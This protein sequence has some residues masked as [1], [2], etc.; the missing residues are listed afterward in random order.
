M[1]NENNLSFH[2]L[3]SL[4]L[5]ASQADGI[6]IAEE[7]SVRPCLFFSNPL[8]SSTPLLSAVEDE[9][10]A[11]ADADD[12]DTIADEMADPYPHTTPTF[13]VNERPF[14]LRACLHPVSCALACLIGRCCSACSFLLV[15]QHI[16]KVAVVYHKRTVLLVYQHPPPPPHYSNRTD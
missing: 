9:H 7:P 4:V 2:R 14:S 8:F 10:K 16:I 1:C 6:T 13:Q 5:V 15:Y 11:A 3:M 12:A